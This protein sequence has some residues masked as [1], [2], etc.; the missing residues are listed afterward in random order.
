[1][2]VRVRIHSSVVSTIFSRSKLVSLS[3]GKCPATQ[4][5]AAAMS[6]DVSAKGRS[7]IQ[8]LRRQKWGVFNDVR[9]KVETKKKDPDMESFL[10]ITWD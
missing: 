3:S 10:S 5:I 1:M 6:E 7:H 2:P 8:A 9:G 4:V